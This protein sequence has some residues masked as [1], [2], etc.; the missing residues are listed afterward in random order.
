MNSP[1][2]YFAEQKRRYCEIQFTA[3]KIPGQEKLF[4][5]EQKQVSFCCARVE[6]IRE[7]RK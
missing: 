3:Y 6:G 2:V 4:Y 7:F 5:S 1:Q